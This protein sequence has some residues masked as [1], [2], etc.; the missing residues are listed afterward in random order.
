MV[1]TISR[2]TCILSMLLWKNLN[3]CE[4][5]VGTESLEGCVGYVTTLLDLPEIFKNVFVAAELARDLN[6]CFFL[7]KEPFTSIDDLSITGAI[8]WLI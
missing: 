1:S 6:W 2:V 7:L 5:C 8:L 4:R 3:D